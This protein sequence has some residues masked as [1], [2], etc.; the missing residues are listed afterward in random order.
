MIGVPPFFKGVSHVNR[1]ESF[2][3]SECVKFSGGLGL[4][5]DQNITILLLG[6]NAFMCAK[7]ND[8]WDFTNQWGP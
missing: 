4:S 3:C 5:V 2:V 1:Q 8:I 7:I 6:M